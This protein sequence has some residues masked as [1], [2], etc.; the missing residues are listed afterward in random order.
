MKRI[1]TQGAGLFSLLLALTPSVPLMAQE[2]LALDEIV[3]RYVA[4]RGGY[5]RI[6]AIRTLVYSAGRY[7]DGDYEGSGKAYM[8]FT[9]PYYR[10]VGNPESPGGYME[11]YDGAA[12]EWYADPGVVVRTVGAAAGA[13]RRGAD[14][15]GM[16]VNYREKDSASP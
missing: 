2:A 4:A 8:A 13:T 7:Q 9:R 16:L 11:G 1:M 5:E 3:D 14:F 10:V 12:W 15:E 6:E